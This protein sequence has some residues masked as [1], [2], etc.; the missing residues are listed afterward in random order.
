MSTH[1]PFLR[2]WRNFLDRSLAWLSLSLMFAAVIWSATWERGLQQP[3]RNGWLTLYAFLTGQ[4][5]D[6]TSLTLLAWCAL[7]G[8]LLATVVSGW[9]FRRWQRQGE[10]RVH[11]LRGSQLGD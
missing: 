2:Q 3:V 11:H 1:D 10:L 4:A 8:V 5:T 7:S 6:R 9:L